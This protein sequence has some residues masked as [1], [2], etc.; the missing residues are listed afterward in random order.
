MPPTAWSSFPAT[1]LNF[2]STRPSL[3]LVSFLMQTG[4]V[5]WPD[6]FN[7]FGL[8]GAESS[9]SIA[10]LAVPLPV[11]VALQPG[12][13]APVFMSSKLTV[14][15]MA[16]AVAMVIAIIVKLNAFIVFLL[17]DTRLTVSAN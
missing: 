8:L 15:A 13:G 1:G 5:A 11:C 3:R 16:L 4:K 14:W 2:T 6:C 12:G 17:I 9:F 7:T 10:H